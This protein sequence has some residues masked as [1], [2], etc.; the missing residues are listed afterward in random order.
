MEHTAPAFAQLIPDVQEVRHYPTENHVIYQVP[1]STVLVDFSVRMDRTEA[2]AWL[3]QNWDGINE[4]A[5][6]LHTVPVNCSIEIYRA[7]NMPSEGI[8][9]QDFKRIQ[10]IK[11]Q[12]RKTQWV[13]SP[14]QIADFVND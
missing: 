2:K 9:T 13:A 14:V 11:D 12:L 10:E 7:W 4:N 5:R 1:F 6:R 8:Q 3:T